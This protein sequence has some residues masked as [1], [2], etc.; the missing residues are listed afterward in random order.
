MK[1]KRVKN[2]RNGKV[3]I[4]MLL[5]G[6]N[7]FETDWLGGFREA[8]SYWLD[9]TADPVVTRWRE[10][11]RDDLPGAWQALKEANW[12]AD[13][14]NPFETSFAGRAGYCLLT[15]QIAVWAAA[16]ALRD[17]PLPTPSGFPDEPFERT[18]PWV[19]SWVAMIGFDSD[20][21][22]ASAGPLI[23]AACGGLPEE[24]TD[25]LQALEPL[26]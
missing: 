23:A 4:S 26:R 16:W 20:T 2:K 14:F 13:S 5:Q 11:V 8:F 25:G 18:G 21:Y 9:G 12:N 22:G 17:Q 10:N 19:L 1:G 6:T 3:V 15:L 24:L 7:P